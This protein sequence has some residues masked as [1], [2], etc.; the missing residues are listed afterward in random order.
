M[1]FILYRSSRRTTQIITRI[2]PDLNFKKNRA[3][4]AGQLLKRT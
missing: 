3:G 4:Q 1:L 2:D